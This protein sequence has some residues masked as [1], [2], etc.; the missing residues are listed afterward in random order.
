MGAR[1]HEVGLRQ[2]EEEGDMGKRMKSWRLGSACQ[3]SFGWPAPGGDVV[4]GKGP[5]GWGSVSSGEEIQPFLPSCVSQ[6][7]GPCRSSQ[8]LNCR[9]TLFLRAALLHSVSL[10]ILNFPFFSGP[11]H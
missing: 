3:Q 1:K 8:W 7:R 10:L 6:A 5:S 9:Y 4:F 11:F 2:G